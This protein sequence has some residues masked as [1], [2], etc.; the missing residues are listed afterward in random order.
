MRLTDSDPIRNSPLEDLRIGFRVESSYLR[1][2]RDRRDLDTF[3]VWSSCRNLGI[4]VVRPDSYVQKYPWFPVDSNL[5]GVGES[6]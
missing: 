4:V 6:I 5:V 1:L 3:D 2:I